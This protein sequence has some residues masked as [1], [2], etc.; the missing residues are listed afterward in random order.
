MKAN[1]ILIVAVDSK[2]A[3]QRIL[4]DIVGYRI[5]D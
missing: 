2:G 1:K 3:V 4:R 5:L